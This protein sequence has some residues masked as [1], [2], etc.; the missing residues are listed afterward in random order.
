[1]IFTTKKSIYSAALLLS[2]V[3]TVFSASAE[4]NPV[5][6]EVLVSASLTPIAQ[7]R[8]ANAVTVI[9]SEQLKNRA[10]LTVS[11][12][13]RVVPGLAVSRSGVLGSN[14]PSSRARCRV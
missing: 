8:S 6:E 11:D 3:S 10:A 2:A 13:L 12:L 9:D 14:T 1:M 5:I 7:S 4:T